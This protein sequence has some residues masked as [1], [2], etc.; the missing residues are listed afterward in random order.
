MIE[1]PA[2]P[3]P[4][5]SSWV[6]GSGPCQRPVPRALDIYGKVM[7]V[8]VCATCSY[9]LA[10]VEYEQGGA[11]MAWWRHRDAPVGI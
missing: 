3:F 4:R 8:V 7:R 2:K 9:N 5:D 10:L 1:L 11:R 6:W